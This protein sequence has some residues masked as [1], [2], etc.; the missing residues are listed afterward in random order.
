[1]PEVRTVF[2]SREGGGIS[3]TL[4]ACFFLSTAAWYAQQCSSNKIARDTGS[5]KR[6]CLARRPQGVTVEFRRTCQTQRGRLS[7]G[8]AGTGLRSLY[9]LIAI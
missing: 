8:L 5:R 4:H 3:S 2:G 7:P 9:N 6:Q 1:M